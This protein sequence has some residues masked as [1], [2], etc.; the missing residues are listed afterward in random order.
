[1]Q[2]GTTGKRDMRSSSLTI[3]LIVILMII[4]V[5][6]LIVIIGL[7]VMVS[8]EGGKQAASGPIFQFVDWAQGTLYSLFSNLQDWFNYLMGQIEK[9]SRTL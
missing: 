4:I 8:T 5:L 7:T 2:G 6:A 9:L 3:L 1:M